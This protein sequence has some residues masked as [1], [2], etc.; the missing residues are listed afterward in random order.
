MTEQHVAVV[1][2]GA[3]GIGAAIAR[4]MAERGLQVAI[5]DIDELA[6]RRVVEELT[7]AGHTARLYPCDITQLAAVRSVAEDIAREL[8]PVRVLV[9]NA[10][11]TPHIRFLDQD[12]EVWGKIIAINYTAVLNTC[13]VFAGSMTANGGIVNLASDAARAGTPNEAVYAGAKAA[14]LAFSKSLSVEIAESGVR[15]NVVAPGPTRTPL[16]LSL[17]DEEELVRRARAIPLGRLGEP[18]DVAAVV[19]FLAL[20]ANHVTGQVIS[21]NGGKRRLG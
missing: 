21:V 14:T 2:G 20:D 7:S 8:G 12:P 13:H 6:G 17:M 10:G 4:Q 3:Q 1:T 15:V 9:N 5:L 18:E 11:W 19:T 16:L